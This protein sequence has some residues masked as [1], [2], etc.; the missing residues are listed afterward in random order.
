MK[1][2]SQNAKRN[3]NCNRSHRSNA[4]RQQPRKDSN[5]KRVNFDNTRVDK[6]DSDVDRM[7]RSAKQ[8]DDRSNDVTWYARTPELLKSASSIPF[9]TTVGLRPAI[10]RNISVPG[11]L[12]I[13]WVPTVGGGDNEP[14]NQAA[15]SKYSFT[16]HKNSR[17]YSYDPADQMKMI[18]A[19]MQV[20]CAIAAGIRAYG[21]MRRFNQR[22][23]FTP[24]AL[25]TA[26]GF[27]YAD[28]R[29]NLPNAWFGLNELISRAT[30]IWIPDDMPVMKRWFW[31]NSNVYRDGGSVKSQYYVF[32]QSAYYQYVVGSSA[33]QTYLKATPMNIDM[34]FADYIQFVNSLINPLLQSQDRG[35]IFG[36]L[37]N[38]YGTEH[39]FAMNTI[40]SDYA[41]EPAYDRE[42][43]TQIENMCMMNTTPASIK[44]DASSGRL[45]ENWRTVTT[46]NTTATPTTQVIN[47]HQL[48]AP[49]PEQ[50]MVATRL[51]ATGVW[52]TQ[53]TGPESPQYQLSPQFYGTEVVNNI[54][55]ISIN[56]STGAPVLSGLNLNHVASSG[57]TYNAD[58]FERWAAFDWAPWLYL[59]AYQS[60]PTQANAALLIITTLAIGDYD[61][62]TYITDKDLEKMHLAAIYSEFG[63]PVV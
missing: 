29:Q 16:V 51:K 11:V 55:A 2:Q 13:D 33:D 54:V 24:E 60:E 48:E 38:A 20:F 43:L 36:D 22:D 46:A 50:I 40:S 31:M 21:I 5:N 4:K 6:F 14:I 7:R 27:N 61:N 26:M 15:N 59:T 34:K 42:V 58:F 62:Y 18:I 3:N 39:I 53:Y 25:I 47:F 37:M 8:T 9:S 63:V 28:W 30:Q 52:V 1:D 32:R 57:A 44:E 41:V 49:T 10:N 35:I 12:R 56:W 17:N 23:F 45:V 19:G